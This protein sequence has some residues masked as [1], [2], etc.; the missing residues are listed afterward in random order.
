MTFAPP[1]RIPLPKRGGPNDI[2]SPRGGSPVDHLQDAVD[3]FHAYLKV[4][5]D[6]G[7]KAVATQVL[8]TI[9]KLI[10]K[11]Q[12]DTLK[13]LGVGPALTPVLKARQRAAAGGSN[14][15]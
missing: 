12:A 8:A 13:G 4:E 10:A 1:S 5:G 3:A 7:D 14:G 2:S 6:P 9:Q 15:Y 11:D